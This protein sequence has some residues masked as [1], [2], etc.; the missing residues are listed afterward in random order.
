MDSGP[1]INASYSYNGLDSRVG[2]TENSVSNTFRCNGAY[3]TDPVL[4]DVTASYTPGV[5][6][7]QGTSISYQHGGLKN[8]DAQTSVSQNVTAARVYDAFGN[9]VTSTGAWAGPFGYAG[10]FGYQQDASGLKMLGHRYYDPST[11]RFLTRDPIKDGRNWYAY[12]A[13]EA[14]P[15]TIT[16]PTGL[17]K[18]TLY[19]YGVGGLGNHFFLVIEDNVSGSPTFGEKWYV[20]GYPVNNGGKFSNGFGPDQ[21]LAGE[22]VHQSGRPYDGGRK[23]HG[24]IVLVDDQSPVFP[25]VEGA[26]Y[27]TSL[28]STSSRYRMLHGDNSNTFFWYTLYSLGLLGQFEHAMNKRERAGYWKPWAP[29]FGAPSQWPS[30]TI[31][32]PSYRSETATGQTGGS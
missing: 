20:S 27:A 12:G 9:L 21:R 7:R 16:D 22:V 26:R 13:G 5:S 30:G 32:W 17:V 15:T 19:W 31:K 11:G 29:G 28:Y 3:V 25:W 23:T 6:R 24:G 8:L 2:K 18:I 4:S 14:A 10:G 1:G